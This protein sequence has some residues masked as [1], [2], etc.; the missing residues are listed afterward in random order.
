M[1]SAEEK[2]QDIRSSDED[3]S[4]EEQ[5]ED[6]SADEDDI[7]RMEAED[8]ATELTAEEFLARKDRIDHRA[9]KSDDTADVLRISVKLAP[10][11]P[12]EYSDLIQEMNECD[13]F[14]KQ[15]EVLERF[16]TLFPLLTPIWKAWINKEVAM[17]TSTAKIEDLFE[18][19]LRD[20]WSSD[21]CSDYIQWVVRADS[22]LGFV[23]IKEKF[24]RILQVVGLRP[25]CAALF[26]LGYIDYV[27]VL[28]SLSP[29]SEA[30]DNGSAKDKAVNDMVSLYAR[31]LAVPQKDLND[32]WTRY[33]KFVDE[34][35]SLEVSPEIRKN[36][37]AALKKY[38]EELAQL[39]AN[40]ASAT[41]KESAYAAYVDYELDNGDPARI[42]LMFERSVELLPFCS[43]LWYQYLRWLDVEL[44]VHQ[45]IIPAYD[46]GCKLCFSSCILWERSL[47]AL[48]RA[49]F[50]YEASKGV[51]EEA[52]QAV[53]S[54][55][56]GISLYLTYTAVTR[57]NIVKSGNDDLTPVV[58]LFEEGLGYLKETDW[59]GELRKAYALFLYTKLKQVDK[60]RKI[61]NDILASGNGNK[62][63]FWLDAIQ[64]ER[65]YGDVAHAR[66]LF[67]RAVNSTSDN[68]K[69]VFD[70]FIQFERE[71]GTLVDLDAAIAKV[72]AQAKRM[73][74]RASDTKKP[75]RQPRGPAKV[76]A[77]ETG[78]DAKQRA[79]RQPQASR[80]SVQQA[81]EGGQKQREKPIKRTQGTSDASVEEAA[82]LEKKPRVDADGFKVPLP[83]SA[84]RKS[85]AGAST[86]SNAESTALPSREHERAGND[87][88]AHDGEQD[89]GDPALTVFI[90]NL[91]FRWAVNDLLPL[92]ENVKE[93]RLGYGYIDF[94][95]EPSAKAAVANDRKLKI[96]NRPIFIS[97]YKP[98][99]KGEKAD[100]K[101]GTGLERT[102]LFVRNVH[103]ACT[104]DELQEF[105]SR[106]ASVKDVRI[107]E[108]KSGQRKGVAYVEFH[109]EQDASKALI[110]SNGAELRGR[111]L[112]VAIS[113]PPGPQRQQRPDNAA[114]GTFVDSNA[115]LARA[116]RSSRLD[117]VPR[118]L[119]P[120]TSTGRANGAATG[121]GQPN[122][123]SQNGSAASAE[124]RPATNGLSNDSFRQFLR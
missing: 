34:H 56:E 35:D 101:F 51:W 108:H 73:H 28:N 5:M 20:F 112:Q 115:S 49:G 124:N 52:K 95:D 19:A 21:V 116:A 31:A 86:T 94:L 8:D 47:L 93:I 23:Q 97:A 44:K 92:F 85:S 12:T 76:P 18:S 45:V 123:S 120:S 104:Q 42:Q 24:E 110:A 75:Q 106:Y 48:E 77:Q 89:F 98:H 66:K 68:P 32:I 53:S 119:R 114:T 41:E 83:P 33:L 67:S 100:F 117:L 84:M 81:P 7:A 36:Y 111:A 25:D 29:E 15:R 107:V 55:A 88:S 63:H 17:G 54:P 80:A 61:W 59:D 78:N 72:N 87:S 65:A 26:W 109:T 90:S 27:E 6:M 99:K 113:N 96:N 46:R 62:A 16:R 3:A 64:L 43:K 122:A 82:T 58:E 38:S 69:L 60:A 70:A 105:F 102:K 74:V 103:Y 2:E 10:G 4:D 11:M 9:K 79:T 57:R 30:N 91:D 13:S 22:E 1:T 118:S 50:D 40:L 71:E 39:E 121:V 37:E 14:S